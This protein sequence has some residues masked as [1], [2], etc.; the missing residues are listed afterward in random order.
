MKKLIFLLCLPVLI[1]MGCMKQ[2]P[3]ESTVLQYFTPLGNYPYSFNGKIQK[4]TEKNY[5][6]KVDNGKYLKGNKITQKELDS[7]KWMPDYE[8]NLNRDGLIENCSAIDENGKTIWKNQLKIENS[9]YVVNQFYRNDTLRYY[10]N[11]K[12]NEKGELSEV[13]RYRP[14]V[15]TLIVTG[16]VLRNPTGDTITMKGLNAKGEL[17]FSNIQFLNKEKKHTGA[18]AYGPNGEFNGSTECLYN[19]KGVIQKFSYFDKD[20]NLTNWEEYIYLEYDE[21]D[22]VILACYKDAEGRMAIT[23]RTYTYYEPEQ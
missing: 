16:V 11:I 18:E 13:S 5:W 6:G 10:E 4:M 17:M 8:V 15:D 14:V 2:K 12:Y 22:N 3:T 1:F 7:M 23:E 19:D 21:K 20:K 9:K